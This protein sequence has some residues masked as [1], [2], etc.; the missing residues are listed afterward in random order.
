MN[1]KIGDE[2]VIIDPD[3]D[4]LNG[5]AKKVFTI[6]RTRPTKF[7]NGKKFSVKELKQYVWFYIDNQTEETDRCCYVSKNNIRKP[8]KLEKI[9]K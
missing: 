8:N 9:L 7:D 1:W 6:K 2:F 4:S 3:K 5:I